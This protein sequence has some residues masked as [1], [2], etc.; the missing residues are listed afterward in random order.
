[1]LTNNSKILQFTDIHLDLDYEEGMS[2]D[3]P[4]PICCREKYGGQPEFENVTAGPYGDY[5]CGLPPKALDAMFE[6]AKTT[7]A[8]RRYIKSKFNLQFNNIT[9][10]FLD[11]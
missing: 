8:V 9:Y 1:M 3:C 6:H 2:T 7:H 5:H 4:Y 10:T 11:V